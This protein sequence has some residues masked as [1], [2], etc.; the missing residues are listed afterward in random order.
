MSVL[1]FKPN[2]SRF[3]V[4]GLFAATILLVNWS[5][6]TIIFDAWLQFRGFHAHGL[7]M[8][9]GVVY[10]LWLARDQQAS[11]LPKYTALA[12]WLTLFGTV[13]FWI[14]SWGADFQPGEIIGL[15][16]YL[17][18]GIALLLGP[19]GTKVIAPRVAILLFAIPVWFPFM[20]LLQ[21]LATF[22]VSIFLELLNV[23][24]FVTGNVIQLPEGNFEIEG[25]CS[26]LS[27]LL[28]SMSMVSYLS[29]SEKLNI[30]TTIIAA[31]FALFLALLSNWIRITSIVL[32]GYYFGMDHTLVQEHVTFG[33]IL[34]FCLFLPTILLGLSYLDKRPGL[35]SIHT[36]TQAVDQP[37]PKRWVTFIVLI[38]FSMGMP[39]AQIASQSST[40][41]ISKID[42]SDE[43]QKLKAKPSSEDFVWQP[44]LVDADYEQLENFAFAGMPGLLYAAGFLLQPAERQIVNE[45]A[46]LIPDGWRR[47]PS[48]SNP[49]LMILQ[50]QRRAHIA[51]K[52]WYDIGGQIT[53]DRL[54]AKLLRVKSQLTGRGDTGMR[55]IALSCVNT[56]CDDAARTVRE[57]YNLL[58]P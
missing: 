8:F 34:Y 48:L 39:I 50:S 18:L 17:V 7:L 37:V 36:A 26:G 11:T 40:R 1:A 6:T 13:G 4:A 27:Y 15:F 55:A 28:A 22:V 10:L 14:I 3:L 42:L 56:S 21:S 38:T 33:W 58:H 24:A 25:G 46:L 19:F 54:D 47:I 2:T 32:T 12:C 53:T 41:D 30:K 45:A 23:T 20:P 51:V 16:V 31:L 9:V 5:T 57:I 29:F 44:T 35:K 52:F 49:D 43:L